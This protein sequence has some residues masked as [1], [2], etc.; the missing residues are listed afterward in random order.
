[1]GKSPA[2]PA[3]AGRALVAAVLLLAAG[4][5][6][7]LTWQDYQSQFVYALEVDGEVV[8]YLESKETWLEILDEL[9]TEAEAEAGLPV[10][11]ESDVVLTKVRPESEDAVALCAD[12]GDLAEVCRE[13]LSF[14]T[15]VWA[16]A[17]DGVEVAYLRSEGEARQVGPGL[18]E[19]YRRS[20][21]AKG[22]TVVLSASLVEKLEY[23]RTRAPVADLVDVEGAK[24]ILLRGTDRVEVHV[25]ARGESLWTIAASHSLTV[26]D[27][28]RANPEVARTDLIRVGQKLNLIV[29]NP[30]VTLASTERFTYIQYLPFAQEVRY[31]P[32]KWPWESY[33]EK[34]GVSGRVE[35]TVEIDRRNGDE[36]ARR[37]L[38]ERKLSDPTTQLYVR[39][40]KTRP[41]NPSGL[42]WPA[43]GAITSAF[44]WRGREFH[45]G[46]D[47]GAPH[48]S[49]VVAAKGGVVTFA[50]RSG[51]YGYLVKIDHGG[52][53]ETWYAH[54]SSIDVSVGQ[55]VTAG[56]VIGRVGNTGRSYGAHLHFETRVDG[57]PVNPVGYY[58][59]G[60]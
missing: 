17:V 28:R 51:G 39:G 36:V 24:R 12:A 16:L 11:L 46:M 32:S 15:E 7:G 49:P 1:M 35:V 2:P 26:Q 48:G 56:Q 31:D 10:A 44:G 41:V 14:V 57:S 50:G 38:T 34:R 9:E 5:F 60:G 54:L 42:Y 27:L 33:V 8:A 23:Y 6:G 45:S 29:P 47:I 13:H 53:F 19:D 40:T 59:P 55:S 58:P 30:Y 52:G 3:P 18:V 20:L 37:P 25:V 22:N 4:L 21:E 43:D